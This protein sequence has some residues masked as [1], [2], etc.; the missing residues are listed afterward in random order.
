MLLG[1]FLV[2]PIPL[3]PTDDFNGIEHAA[4]ESLDM[5][6]DDDDRARLL[7]NDELDSGNRQPL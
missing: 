4:E 6:R 1:L 7:E 3:P 5:G 2:V